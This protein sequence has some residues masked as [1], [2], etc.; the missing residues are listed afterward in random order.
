MPEGRIVFKEGEY[1]AEY[2]FKDHLGN[3]RLAFQV[4]DRQNAR[5]SSTISQR[6]WKTIIC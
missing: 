3:L 6:K 4:T 2:H 1:I 5:Y